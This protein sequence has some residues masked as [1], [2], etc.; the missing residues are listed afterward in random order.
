MTHGWLIRGFV[1]TA[2]RYRTITIQAGDHSI[3]AA[4]PL[5]DEL[6]AALDVIHG[7]H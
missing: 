4:D 7:T 5:P 2:R 6:R 1:T 3:I